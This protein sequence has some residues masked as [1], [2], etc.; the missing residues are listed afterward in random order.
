MRYLVR[1]RGGRRVIEL[2]LRDD[3]DAAARFNSSEHHLTLELRRD[4]VRVVAT[5]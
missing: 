4:P 1:G 2:G 5:R 3:I